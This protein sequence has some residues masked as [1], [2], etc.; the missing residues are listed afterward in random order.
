M[1]LMC[2]DVPKDVVAATALSLWVVMQRFEPGTMPDEMGLRA[3]AA[4]VLNAVG[5]V[6]PQS[7]E[8]RSE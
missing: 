7:R 5:W 1:T 6:P 4:N 3:I 8:G 2:E